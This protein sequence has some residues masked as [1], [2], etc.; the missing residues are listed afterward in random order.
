MRW[1][2]GASQPASR[3]RG[4]H[5]SL[6]AA[7]AK[8]NC[9]WKLK[10]NAT[11]AS[12]FS[13][14]I[15]PLQRH[16]AQ[17]FSSLL[18]FRLFAAAEISILNFNFTAKLYSVHHHRRHAFWAESG[19]STHRSKLIHIRQILVHEIRPENPACAKAESC[20]VLAFVHFQKFHFFG[21]NLR[22]ISTH[23]RRHTIGH[24]REQRESQNQFLLE[25]IRGRKQ[26]QRQHI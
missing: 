4:R 2:F 13:I 22:K 19:P 24:T 20:V 6:T 3:E 12:M 25:L 18:L 15:I 9:E 8:L 7:R 21:W 23:I 14:K 5:S 1:R 17:L 11:T 10:K 26:Q 16:R